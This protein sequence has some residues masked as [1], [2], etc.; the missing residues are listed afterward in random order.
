MPPKKDTKKIVLIKK[1][2]K[3]L[4]MIPDVKNTVSMGPAIR[5]LIREGTKNQI[6]EYKNTPHF[7]NFQKVKESDNHFLLNVRISKL[8]VEAV[9]RS[10]Q[11]YL[12]E[13]GRMCQTVVQYARRKTLLV[14]DILHVVKIDGLLSF[15]G[16]SAAIKYES[17]MYVSK[18]QTRRNELSF[19]SVKKAFMLG[20]DDT[21]RF[22][23][24]AK[25]TLIHLL[26]VYVKSIGMKAV[27]FTHS[28]K[29]ETIKADDVMK[30]LMCI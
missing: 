12:K 6:Y 7:Q 3:E 29:R 19:P 27:L 2:K 10:V 4:R 20:V 21:F 9:V 5:R 14:D 23:A 1:S 26:E 13:L 11:N 18:L 22:S 30:A 16:A 8:A 25:R 28:A 24:D 15:K 17:G